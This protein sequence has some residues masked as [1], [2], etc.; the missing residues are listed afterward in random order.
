VNDIHVNPHRLDGLSLSSV[1]ADARGQGLAVK[2]TSRPV[3]LRVLT[4]DL[5]SEVGNEHGGAMTSEQMRRGC[6]DAV[7][8]PGYEG[9]MTVTSGWAGM[10]Q[11]LPFERRRC[12]YRPQGSSVRLPLIGIQHCHRADRI[13]DWRVSVG[14]GQAMPGEK[15]AEHG[16]LRLTSRSCSRSMIVQPRSCIPPKRSKDPWRCRPRHPSPWTAPAG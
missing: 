12:N 9:H 10:I 7:I 16:N 6:T 5:G 2:A 13:A 8:G 11:F 1:A 14:A 3:W 15:T 4:G